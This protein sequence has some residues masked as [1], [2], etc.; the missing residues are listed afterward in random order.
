VLETLE[1]R[2][3]LSSATV[4]TV[5]STA[6]SGSGSL[7]AA[8]TQANNNGNPAGS[9]IQFDR[10]VFGSPQTITLSGTLALS[11][12]AGP[13]VIDGPGSG[14]LTISGNHS[15]EVFLVTTNATT[16][17]LSGLTI[18]GGSAPSGGGIDNEG[19]LSLTDCTIAGNSVNLATFAN[20]GGGGIYNNGT[21]TVTESTISGNSVKPTLGAGVGG[22]IE[23]Y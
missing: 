3:L 6:S 8:I 13:E 7:P 17:T 19:W 2:V 4:F 16:A 10:T 11:G 15:F 9:I 23:N 12:K 5:T 22:G 1:D 14:L 20:G 18:T 21:L